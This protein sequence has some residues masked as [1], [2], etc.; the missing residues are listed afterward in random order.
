M[1]D[2][3]ALSRLQKIDRIATLI[4]AYVTAD[5]LVME[6]CKNDV[7]DSIRRLHI[8]T[9]VNFRY[10]IQV[11]LA[12]LQPSSC[13]ARY[14]IDQICY[15]TVIEGK[16]WFPDT[17]E[18]LSEFLLRGGLFVLEVFSAVTTARG[19]CQHKPDTPDPVCIHRDPAKLKGCHYHEHSEDKTCGEAQNDTM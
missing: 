15:D 18:D 17:D 10:L 3:R 19:K 8:G 1:Y 9:W 16:H 13:V 2:S 12:G 6:D 4:G 7:L 11:D 14:L 5:M